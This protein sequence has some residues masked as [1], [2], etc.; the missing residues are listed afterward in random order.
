MVRAHVEINLD[1]YGDERDWRNFYSWFIKGLREVIAH[2][3]KW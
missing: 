3:G 1:K 2:Y